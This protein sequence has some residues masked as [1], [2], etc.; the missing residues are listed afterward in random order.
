MTTE[1]KTVTVELNVEAAYEQLVGFSSAA[2]A[3]VAAQEKDDKDGMI[4][5]ANA[6]VDSSIGLINDLMPYDLSVQ[7]HD[8]LEKEH[9]ELVTPEPSL[10]E[11]LKG[12]FGEDFDMSLVAGLDD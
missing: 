10:E 5:A 7:L 6:A 3:F 12:L 2:K 8:R 11:V 4:D 1:S 9:P